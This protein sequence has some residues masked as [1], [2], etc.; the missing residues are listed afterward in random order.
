MEDELIPR[1]VPAAVR[2]QLEIAA[3]RNHFATQRLAGLA[4]AFAQ[5]T[6]QRQAFRQRRG[7]LKYDTWLAESLS[8]AG[9]SGW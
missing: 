4:F 1:F 6:A 7:V 3:R 9:S 5:S 8:F 2:R